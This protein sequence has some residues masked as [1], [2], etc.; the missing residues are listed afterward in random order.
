MI[1]SES[2]VVCRRYLRRASTCIRRRRPF[3][4]RAIAP[5]EYAIEQENHEV[6]L[7]LCS[8]H[9]SSHARVMTAPE[10][11]HFDMFGKWLYIKPQVLHVLVFSI[12]VLCV[13]VESSAKSLP[14][15][16]AF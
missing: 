4:V 11:A 12:V 16:K 1:F 14:H 13:V 9:R 5:D 15:A 7:V 10:I 2:L 6:T 3:L 8:R